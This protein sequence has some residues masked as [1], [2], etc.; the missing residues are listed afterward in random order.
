MLYMAPDLQVPN[1]VS[2]EI[3]RVD[4]VQGLFSFGRHHSEGAG[5]M[6]IVRL[7]EQSVIDR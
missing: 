3:N 7:S 4:V 1:E 2:E 6:R 5:G